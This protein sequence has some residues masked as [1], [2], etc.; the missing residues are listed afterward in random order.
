MAAEY[1]ALKQNSVQTFDQQGQ[2]AQ[3]LRPACRA[4]RFFRKRV[5]LKAK[6][7]KCNGDFTLP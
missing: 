3:Q 4:A 2:S 1:G 5:N 6:Q 7:S